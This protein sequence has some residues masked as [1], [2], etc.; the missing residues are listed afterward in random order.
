[1][2]LEQLLACSLLG[3]VTSIIM[4]YV[5][6][7]G[8]N[9]PVLL[10][11]TLF[12]ATFGWIVG[13][14][15]IFVTGGLELSLPWFI[16]PAI[17]TAFGSAVMLYVFRDVGAIFKMPSWIVGRVT[18]VVSVVIIA[19]LVVSIVLLAMPTYASSYNTQTF[20]VEDATITGAVTL[21]TSVARDLNLVTPTGLVLVSFDTAT[22][23][24]GFPRISENPAEE[25]YLEFQLT[26]AV[27]SGSGNWEQPYIAMAVFNDAN[28]NGQP[29]DGEEL[30]SDLY[31]KGPTQ[32]GNWRG[33]CMYDSSGPRGEIFVVSI[34]GELLL[35]PIFHASSITTWADDQAHSH[36]NTPEGYTPPNDMMSWELSE[37]QVSLKEQV[38][39]FATVSAGT[40][41]TFKGKIYCPSGSVGTHG[42]LVRAFDARY[43]NPYTPYEDP[44]AEHVMTFTVGGD[45][46]GNGNGYPVVD[47]TSESWV[48]V[49]MLGI[50][51]IGGAGAVI[52]KGPKLLK[53]I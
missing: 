22:S 12:G 29:D 50:S 36:P 37:N 7:E 14:V 26:F 16:L 41:V 1:M 35:L 13:M 34:G 40:S 39:A 51:T 19:L 24:V 43:T 52:I 49:A 53:Y 18:S 46:N 15:F 31:Y 33:N 10:F 32:S 28:G 11:M 42:L 30:W 4:W 5:I 20:S 2:L 21:S 6:N 3:V 38:T 23:S 48:V 8:K 27:G 25:Q 17:T 9:A 45:E 47:V 44:L